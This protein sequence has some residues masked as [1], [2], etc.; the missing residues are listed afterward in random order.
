[1][2]VAQGRNAETYLKKKKKQMYL[3]LCLT[4]G[5]YYL[6]PLLGL[7]QIKSWNKCQVNQLVY[8]AKFTFR[9]QSWRNKWYSRQ[10]HFTSRWYK[11]QMR[12]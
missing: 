6:F 7:L 5:I 8:I 2:P 1:M 3:I 12:N 11:V 10:N 4:Q 9:K